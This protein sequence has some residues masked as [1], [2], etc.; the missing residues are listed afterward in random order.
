LF[1]NPSFFPSPPKKISH[2]PYG[3]ISNLVD[4]DIKIDDT[5]PDGVVVG[6]ALDVVLDVGVVALSVMLDAEGS[7][8]EEADDDI[9]DDDETDI[10]VGVGRGEGEGGWENVGKFN[11]EVEA[12]HEF[13][14]PFLFL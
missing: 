5:E 9:D 1:Q 3:A 7:G 14:L 2:E 11:L 12:D 6:V 4:F 10:S 13:L 8:V